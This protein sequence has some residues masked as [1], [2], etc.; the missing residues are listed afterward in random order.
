MGKFKIERA[1][2]MLHALACICS[3]AMLE[4]AGPDSNPD[5]DKADEAD[6]IGSGKQESGKRGVVGSGKRESDGAGKGGQGDA[7]SD[8]R[9]VGSGKR[10]SDG[11]GKGGQ[12]D[13]GSGKRESDGA[14]KDGQHPWMQEHNNEF[15]VSVSAS[16]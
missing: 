7:G 11:A 16:K 3:A 9:G 5:S 2:N 12:G 14:G 4:V 1:C 15:V 8:K 13:A 10:E 6:G